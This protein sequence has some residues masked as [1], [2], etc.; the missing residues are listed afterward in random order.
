MNKIFSE[1]FFLNPIALLC[2]NYFMSFSLIYDC[3]FPLFQVWV[4]K[5]INDVLI[6]NINI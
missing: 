5:N 1:L 2:E 3:K 6:R 4:L